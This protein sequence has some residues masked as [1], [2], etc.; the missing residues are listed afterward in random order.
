MCKV[1]ISSQFTAF[2]NE[3]RRNSNRLSDTWLPLTVFYFK[4]FI[5]IWVIW[6]INYSILSFKQLSIFK[7]YT[8][9]TSWNFWLRKLYITLVK[10]YVK[11]Y[12]TFIFLSSVHRGCVW[13][14]MCDKTEFYRFKSQDFKKIFQYLEK[15]L[16]AL[17]IRSI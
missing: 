4:R 6:K 12:E 1:N 2:P 8:S 13:C 5:W 17:F 3:D 9:Q 15:L 14:Q 16:I 10:F 11:L 7:C